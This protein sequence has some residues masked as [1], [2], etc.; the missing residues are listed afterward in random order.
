M[1]GF[2]KVGRGSNTETL[3]QIHTVYTYS[4][5]ACVP[6]GIHCFCEYV[7]RAL[8][9]MPPSR[10]SSAETLL[11]L[12]ILPATQ[13]TNKVGRWKHVSLVGPLLDRAAA[14]RSGQLKQSNKVLF[15]YPNSFTVCLKLSEYLKV[16]DK[17]LQC[18]FTK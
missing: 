15:F 12:M 5:F 16:E 18:S 2:Y 14:F 6:G 7:A 10:S 17:Y 1:Y 4:K 8:V 11:A 9:V 13:T 3:T